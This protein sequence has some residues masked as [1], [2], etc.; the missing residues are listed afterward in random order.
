MCKRNRIFKIV[1]Y[2]M[3]TYMKYNGSLLVKVYKLF[4]YLKY[5]YDIN[6]QNNDCNIDT[7][8]QK[9]EY[10]CNGGCH[11]TKVREVFRRRMVECGSC[12]GMT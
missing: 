4:K 9:A 11:G 1:P 3:D 12:T 10:V 5:L 6:F 7:S 2:R 8:V